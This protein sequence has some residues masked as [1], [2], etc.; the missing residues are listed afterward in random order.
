MSNRR[1]GLKVEDIFWSHEYFGDPG[2]STSL[3]INK[4]HRIAAR[5]WLAD[6]S[7]AGISIISMASSRVESYGRKFFLP[8]SHCFLSIPDPRSFF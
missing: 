2:E 1:R 8:H 6:T 5:T 7:H 3:S 4:A